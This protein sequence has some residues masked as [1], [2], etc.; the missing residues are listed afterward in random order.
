MDDIGTHVQDFSKHGWK[1]R[2]KPPQIQNHRHNHHTLDSKHF[3]TPV[4]HLRDEISSKNDCFDELDMQH[5][6]NVNM[7]VTFYKPPLA[8]NGL[9]K[10]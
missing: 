6:Y 3:H 4:L 8:W 5:E 10:A 7:H 1:T 2:R 9:T